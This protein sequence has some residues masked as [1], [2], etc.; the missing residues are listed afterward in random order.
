MMLKVSKLIIVVFITFGLLH[1]N[2]YEYHHKKNIYLTS[3][4]S[5]YTAQ[6]VSPDGRYLAEAIAKKTNLF[7]IQETYT[8]TIWNI[9]HDH[10]TMS[11]SLASG[12]MI[13]ACA[14]SPDNKQLAFTTAL[15][16]EGISLKILRL[17]DI[18]TRTKKLSSK[19]RPP[20]SHTLT[21][22]AAGFAPTRIAFSTDSQSLAMGYCEINY[23]WQRV[24]L[25]DINDTPTLSHAG[26]IYL[27]SSPLSALSFTRDN[28]CLAVCQDKI[29][30][31]FEVHA[32]KEIPPDPT[33]NTNP[34]SKP[35]MRFCCNAS[36]SALAA[37]HH[38]NNILFGVVTTN[39]L[40]VT[41][42]GI[43]ID[44]ESFYP[45]FDPIASFNATGNS[46]HHSISSHG[47]HLSYAQDH[48]LETNQEHALQKISLLRLNPAEQT[49]HTR[50]L[51]E[52]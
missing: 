34:I 10:Y 52:F 49:H 23:L 39:R 15:D 25:L 36:F 12:S 32:M 4:S 29:M 14:F 9:E 51:N 16:A 31:I 21:L 5:R 50:K 11:C 41:V 13:T 19:D 44:Q 42:L 7:P 24:D 37:H 8:L 18:L 28:Y 17:S 3:K 30:N 26:Y 2:R 46:F 48:F 43:I 40:N 27:N 20:V 1:P 6:A 22:R 35:R 38:Y 45:T 47:S 33:A